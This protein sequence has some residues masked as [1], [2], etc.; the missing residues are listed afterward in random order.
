[1]A[2][3][4][5]EQLEKSGAYERTRILEYW[6]NMPYELKVAHARDLVRDFYNNP[7]VPNCHISVGG[8]DS[9]TLTVF[10]RSLG[11]TADEVPAISVSQ[12]EDKSI[13]RVH[14]ALGVIALKPSKNKTQVIREYGYPI[15][16]K[17]VA[18][19]IELL[20]SPPTRTRTLRHAL[21]TG[22]TGEFGG[23]AKGS[24]MKMADKWL[25]LF[26]GA[27]PEGAALGYKA[28]PFKVSDK[29]CYWLKEK[30]VN[31]YMKE[32]D[33]Y[34]YLGLMASEG[35]RREFAL[36]HYGCNWVSPTTKR[37]CPWACFMRDDILRM[38]QEMDAWYQEHWAE[39]N[40]N[41]EDKVDTIIPEI[42]GA[43]EQTEDGHLRTTGAQRTGCS[44][45][46]FGVEREPYPNRFDRLYWRN[47][48]EWRYYM[49]E[50]GFGAV[51][52]YIGVE[53]HKYEQ[54]SVFDLPELQQAE[55]GQGEKQGED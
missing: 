2:L 33:S 43:I 54:M 55:T 4:A 10:I 22:E 16:S 6:Q 40:P 15:I 17:K 28:A 41:P 1:M 20:Q 35:G 23:N 25:R 47:Q 53:W 14:K 37:S 45:C 27:D 21:I 29:C 11:Y 38:A 36:K 42:Y 44:M 19:N 3:S 13:Q 51:L 26:G 30:P 7:E 5:K 9:I 24:K 32:H 31:D 50:L 46:A 34:P 18:A 52:D 8:L 48:K 12:L 49:Y 39:I